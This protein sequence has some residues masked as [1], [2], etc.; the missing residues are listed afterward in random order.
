MRSDK[1]ERKP[2][3]SK[4]KS[5]W[6]AVAAVG[7]GRVSTSRGFAQ[8]RGCR[9]PVFPYHRGEGVEL[10]QDVVAVGAVLDDNVC[11]QGL[12]AASH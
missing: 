7:V 2:E 1:S 6:V 3:N 12:F 4:R 8:W 9:P 5:E 11:D 10:L